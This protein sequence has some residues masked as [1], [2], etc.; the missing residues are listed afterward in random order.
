MKK[1]LFIGIV[2][3]CSV[4]ML[5]ARLATNSGTP[6]AFATGPSTKPDGM[7][8]PVPGSTLG[9]ITAFNPMIVGPDICAAYG[10]PF[11]P[12]T[13]PWYDELNG[14]YTYSINIPADYAYDNVRV[15]IFDPDTANTSG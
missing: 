6:K 3:V 13:S 7:R 2:V 4:V 11:T 5:G 10:D 9:Y 15:E 14:V 8:L 12:T 1:R